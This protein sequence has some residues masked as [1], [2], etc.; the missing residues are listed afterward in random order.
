MFPV[1]NCSIFLSTTITPTDA[2]G[3][4]QTGKLTRAL[5]HYLIRLNPVTIHIWS[6]KIL[7]MDVFLP[8][9]SSGFMKNSSRKEHGKT[10]DNVIKITIRRF[11][12]NGALFV[13]LISYAEVV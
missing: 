10:S 11:V 3:V 5:A 2:R 6:G 7:F 12:C 9:T 1:S 4:I 13:V 8:R